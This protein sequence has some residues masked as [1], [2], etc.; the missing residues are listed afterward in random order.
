MARRSHRIP[1]QLQRRHLHSHFVTR[2]RRRRGLCLPLRTSVPRTFVGFYCVAGA[3]HPPPSCTGSS[4]PNTATALTVDRWYN[5]RAQPVQLRRRQPTRVVHQSF[6]A[7][8]R[9]GYMGI[10]T[11]AARSPTPRWQARRPRWADPCAGDIRATRSA[12]LLRRT[13]TRLSIRSRTPGQARK[14]LASIGSSMRLT[15]GVPCSRQ[16]GLLGHGHASGISVTCDRHGDNVMD[17]FRY[18]RRTERTFN[19]GKRLIYV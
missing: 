6:Q 17:R 11:G 3:A 9:L 16:R 1:E 5:R 4:P 18:G 14:P 15:N 13:R 2:R 10:T 12:A 7:M 8:R 19:P